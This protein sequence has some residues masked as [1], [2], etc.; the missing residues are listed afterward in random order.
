M[1][2][3]IAVTMVMMMMM[4]MMMM[5]MMMMVMVMMMKMMVMT[6]TPRSCSH[7]WL[8]PLY[9]YL[10]IPLLLLQHESYATAFF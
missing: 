7:E 10:L 3:I 6:L 2:T 4:M 8:E 1:V 9:V 5:L